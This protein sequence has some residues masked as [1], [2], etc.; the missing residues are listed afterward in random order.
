MNWSR[1]SATPRQA[2]LSQPMKTTANN[3]WLA[4]YASFVAFATLLLI[5]AGALVTSNDAGLSVPDWPTS[6]GTFRMPRM[7][8]GVK[9]EHGHRMIAGA[10]AILTVLLALWL[11]RSERRRWVRRLGAVAVLTIIA[12]AVLGGITVL[13]YLPVAVSVGHAC[14]A[15]VF[16]C[17]TVS[18]AIFTREDWRW[19]EQTVQDSGTPS[20]RQIAAGTTAAIFL[21]LMLGAAF[22]HN[23]FG[24]IPHVVWAAVVTI[25]VVWVLVR[26]LTTHPRKPDLVRPALL[27][28]VLLVTQIFLGVA[29][30]IE[31]MAAV[32]AP[33]PLLPVVV[34]TTV[35]VAAGA[36][37]LA[38]SLALTLQVF[39]KV[40]ASG[41]ALSSATAS[42]EASEFAGASRA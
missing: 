20:L 17:I 21:Q 7:V 18:L 8:G 36:L 31:K 24:I 30:Y 23:G 28:V 35:H 27:L 37:V 34:T 25:G 3:P 9:F 10:V 42:P 13:F 14:L 29:S 22:R 1:M 33:Q 11:W 2:M 6:F 4:R 19:D 40:T 38:S 39:R 41:R 5:I 26:I 15:Q 16:F 12:Q 32:N